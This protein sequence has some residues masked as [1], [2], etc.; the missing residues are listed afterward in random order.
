MTIG[1]SKIT[2]IWVIAVS[3]LAFFAGFLFNAWHAL[4]P[5]KS[6]D[7]Q[8]ESLLVGRLVKSRTDGVFSA[9]GLCGRCTNKQKDTALYNYQ[10]KAFKED[11]PCGNFSP[12]L[13]QIGF[14]AVLYSMVDMA[15]P[16]SSPT[17]LKLLRAFKVSLLAIVMSLI[18]C[19]FFLEFGSLAAAFVFLGVLLTPWFT[20]LGKDL[21]FCVWTNF[22]PM[23]A[24]LFLLRKEHESGKPSGIQVLLWVNLA[25]LAN[26]II[27]GYEWVSTTLVMTTIP[28]F[29]Y[30]RKG[31][32]PI[33]KIARRISWLVAG[34]LASLLATFTVLAYQVSLVKGKF[35]DG[36][37]WIIFSFQKRSHGGDEL[38]EVYAKQV[39]HSLQDVFLRYF[40]GPAFRFPG[41]M[42][43]YLPWYLDQVFFAE[44]F[45]LFML[46]TFLSIP[47]FNLLKFNPVQLKTLANLSIAT[48]ISVLAPFS[49]YVIFKGHAY[50]HYH[51][52]YITWFMPFCLFGL[53]LV[54]TALSFLFSR[55]RKREK[56]LS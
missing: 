2:A 1:N 17:T 19:W 31:N 38:P 48:W 14:H 6:L 20:F 35:S 7:L 51:I 54:G 41:F 56:F 16:F 44:V 39:N 12:Y 24:G 13:S 23:L 10:Y 37:E 52:N 46:V 9:G 33:R 5:G 55:L 29:F 45:A 36:I 25:V 53:A 4:E 50:S 3:F 28:F 42:T 49:W 18:V 15:S 30:W 11:I 40:G 8:G 34:S 32:W 43:K 22:L 21:W 47:R 26:F 27:N